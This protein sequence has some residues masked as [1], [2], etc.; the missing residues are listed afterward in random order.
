MKERGFYEGIGGIPRVLRESSKGWCS[1]SG[2]GIGEP[3]APLGLKGKNGVW[4]LESRESS[5]GSKRQEMLGPLVEGADK[6]ERNSL[7]PSFPSL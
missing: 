6:E 5:C 7:P 1:S 3:L 2:L 4:L